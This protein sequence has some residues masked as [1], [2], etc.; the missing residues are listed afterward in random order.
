M[1]TPDGDFMDI[2]WSHIGATRCA[3]LLH[4]LEGHSRRSYMLGMA[5]ACNRAGWDVAAVN[6]RGCGGEPNLLPRSYHHGSSDDCAAV[7]DH[8]VSLPYQRIV[9]IGFSLGGNVVLKYLGEAQWGKP[10][11]LVAAVAISTPCD[12]PACARRMDLPE[13][14]FYTRR[15]I[16]MLCEK[17]AAKRGLFPDVINIDG[18]KAL[19][20]FKAFDDRY[21]APLNGFKDAEDYWE[22]SSSLPLL[23]AIA[24]PTLMISAADD[25]FLTPGCFPRKLARNHRFLTLEVPRFGGHVGFMGRSRQGVYWHE[26]RTVS[27]LN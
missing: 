10:P 12:V 3:V 13:S 9:L 25:P 5:R 27:F 26:Q 21:T 2:D 6:L 24:V 11:Q 15:F 18:C 16:T 17:L 19:R 1:T 14:R 4:G 8:V 20:T 7:V 22:R 23:G